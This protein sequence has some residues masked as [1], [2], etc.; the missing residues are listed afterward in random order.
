MRMVAEPVDVRKRRILLP[1]WVWDMRR[2]EEVKH[3]PRAHGTEF[4]LYDLDR[5]E[6]V[7][8]PLPRLVGRV[9]KERGDRDVAG[10]EI[11]VQIRC[12]HLDGMR[13]IRRPHGGELDI[14]QVGNAVVAQLRRQERAVLSAP[15][16]LKKGL[17]LI[18]DIAGDGN[19]IVHGLLRLVLR[20]WVEERPGRHGLR[21]EMRAIPGAVGNGV[22]GSGCVRSALLWDGDRVVQQQVDDLEAGAL[23]SLDDR[24]PPFLAVQVV[25]AGPGRE[26]MPHAVSISLLGSALQVFAPGIRVGQGHLLHVSVR[27]FVGFLD[28]SRDALQLWRVS[29]VDRLLDQRFPVH[30]DVGHEEGHDLP[31]IPLPRDVQDGL[32][33]AG[34]LGHIRSALQ[35]QRD[36]VEVAFP[37]AAVQRRRAVLRRRLHVGA[38]VQEQRHQLQEAVPSG[39]VERGPSVAVRRLHV[40]AMPQQLLHHVDVALQR[41]RVQ[42]GDPVLVR[43]LHVGSALQQGGGGRLLT[44]EGRGVQGRRAVLVHRVQV[45]AGVQQRPES[46]LVALL[47]RPKERRRAGIVPGLQAGSALQQKGHG[48]ALVLLRR[49]VQGRHA[50]LRGRLQLGPL[51]QQQEDHVLSALAGGGVQRSPAVDVGRVHAGPGLQEPLHQLHISVGRRIAQRLP[52]RLR[53]R[54]GAS[55]Q[56]SS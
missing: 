46:R 27:H 9:H 49:G 12:H 35:E 50:V 38:M 52:R 39:A 8:L 16:C 1:T 6:D 55:L 21:C 36:H 17:C 5:D 2:Q 48:T 51:L 22:G 13:E 53:R 30:A 15:S 24:A 56:R 11:H 47:H 43:G 7:G 31:V 18:E 26:E 19:E 45:S 44:V 32:A 41:G 34:V 23:R 33:F 42:R 3:R 28:E 54:H 37:A 40:G 4:R 29:L 20:A 25:D 10:R 14:V